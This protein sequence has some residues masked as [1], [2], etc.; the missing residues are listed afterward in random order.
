MEIRICSST[1]VN[2]LGIIK[3]VKDGTA[4][5]SE[6]EDLLAHDDYQMEFARYKGR[7]SM[8]EFI[9]YLMHFPDLNEDDI[10]NKD[11]KGH[12]SYYL[13]LV[14]NYE[15][16]VNKLLILNIDKETIDQAI[17]KAQYGLPDLSLGKI[18]FVFT[19]GIGQSFG[20]V[21]QNNI[22]MDY[23][24]LVKE[25]TNVDL[26][27]TI[28]HEVHHVGIGNLLNGEFLAE[29][30]LEEMFYLYFAGEGLAVK[31]CNNA[32]GVLSKSIYEGPKNIGLDPFTWK[33]LNNDFEATMVHF[34]KNIDDI[35]SHKISTRD[36]LTNEVVNY[37]MNSYI[38]GQSKRDIPKLKH[39]R[40]YSFGNDI[41]G[42]IHD[43]FG[44][45]KVFETLI[46]PSQFPLAFNAAL[47]MLGKDVYKI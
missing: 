14:E 9:E 28:A 33:Y 25:N 41:W 20:Y 26:G 38:E 27:S 36:E 43:C 37:W 22:H 30:S 21:Y 13:D 44:R 10:S 31:Y 39:F 3:K 5:R 47:E 4:N 29:L 16:Y 19:L 32:E 8:E 34:K 1:I 2:M 15:Y 23:L 7:V 18:N 42:I 40:L 12:H 24:Q 45:E 6:I 11:L 17:K 46:N 35:R